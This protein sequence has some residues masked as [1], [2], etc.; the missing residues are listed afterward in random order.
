[1]VTEG[2]GG[3]INAETQGAGCRGAELRGKH[4]SHVDG[5]FAFW[6]NKIFDDADRLDAFARY[7]LHKLV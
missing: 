1:M 7:G 2:V 5:S 4:D 6:A 3:R